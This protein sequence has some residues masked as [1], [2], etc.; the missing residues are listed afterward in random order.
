PGSLYWRRCVWGVAD[1]VCFVGRPAFVH[2]VEND[3]PKGRRAGE[4]VSTQHPTDCA[5]VGYGV[6]RERMVATWSSA[7]P[8]VAPAELSCRH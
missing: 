5:V 1:A 4:L 6:G 7:G 8:V 3:D 2:V